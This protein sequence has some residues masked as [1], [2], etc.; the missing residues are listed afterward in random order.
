MPRVIRGAY[1]L[2][3]FE[4]RRERRRIRRIAITE[5][6]ATMVPPIGHLTL[7]PRG[8]YG[9]INFIFGFPNYTGARVAELLLLQPATV[10]AKFPCWAW[11]TS[12]GLSPDFRFW[13]ERSR[14]KTTPQGFNVMGI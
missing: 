3:P 6:S 2:L 4:N 13:I 7:Y 10:V 9:A 12:Q 11:T 5:F 8:T 14:F 1:N